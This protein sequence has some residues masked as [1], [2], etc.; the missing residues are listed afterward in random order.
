MA[1]V[2][3]RADGVGAYLA[4]VTAQQGADALAEPGEPGAGDRRLRLVVPPGLLDELGLRAADA[5]FLARAAADLLVQDRAWQDL[6]EEVS[7][8]D[9]GRSRPGFLER[10]RDLAGR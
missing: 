9:L 6:P 8:A 2:D 4:V 1:D 5:P 7:L 3:V 10:A